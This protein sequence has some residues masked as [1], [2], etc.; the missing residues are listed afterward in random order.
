MVISSRGFSPTQTL[1]KFNM[2]KSISIV[3]VDKRPH[4]KVAQE[5][6]GL[7]DEQMSGMHVHHRVPRSEGGTND[8]S[9]LYVCSPT[10]HAHVWHNRQFFI[11]AATKNGHDNVKMK[12]GFLSDEFINS[13]RKK[14]ICKE[15]GS[16]VVKNKTGILN[17]DYL[18][19]PKKKEDC[20]LGGR[21]GGKVNADR[22]SGIC[23]PEFITSEKKKKCCRDNGVKHG[24]KAARV[25]NSQLW[26]S[27]IDGF[28]STAG[29]VARHNKANGWDPA[30]RVRIN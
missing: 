18:N 5:N 26:Q 13:Q 8:P 2:D 28:T 4:R 3:L 10:F 12:R 9:N 25:T 23:N 6:W 7:S 15:Q 14:E 20:A 11:T 21:V 27:T 24:P 16:K 1:A 19:S 30:A 22:K 17:P 29:P